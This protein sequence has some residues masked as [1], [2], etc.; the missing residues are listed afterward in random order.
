MYLI[1]VRSHRLCSL[2]KGVLK[3]VRKFTGKHLCQSLFLRTPLL[4][5]TSGQ[6]LLVSYLSALKYTVFGISQ[7]AKT[8]SK[9]HFKHKIYGLNYFKVLTVSSP[10]PFDWSH[11]RPRSSHQRCSLKKGV[12]RISQS[13]RENTCARVCLIKLQAKGL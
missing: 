13:S 6:L 12:L 7:Q 5:S 9:Q 11:L 10:E 4:Q 1:Q 3:N 2:K 8:C